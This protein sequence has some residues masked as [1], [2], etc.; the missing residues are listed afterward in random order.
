MVVI[1]RNLTMR[2]MLHY[3]LGHFFNADM[4]CRLEGS[5]WLVVTP[6]T[7]TLSTSLPLYSRLLWLVTCALTKSS[8]CAISLIDLHLSQELVKLL[9]TMLSG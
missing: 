1:A 9:F 4:F 6:F 3:L 7:I 5:G 2:N 8:F